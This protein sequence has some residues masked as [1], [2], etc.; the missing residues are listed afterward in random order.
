MT[1]LLSVTSREVSNAEVTKASWYSQAS[2]KAEGTSGITTSGRPLLDGAATAAS[3]VYPIGTRL[4]VRYNDRICTVTVNDRGPGKKALARGVTL[5]LSKGAFS[6]L[7]PL[8][9][10][11]ILVEVNPIGE[12]VSQ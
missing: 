1:L 9:Q 2:C 8:E 10:G 12:E 4:R 11:I 3:W 6:K 5:D 7:A